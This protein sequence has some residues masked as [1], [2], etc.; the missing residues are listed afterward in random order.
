MNKRSLGTPGTEL[1][2][3]SG[4]NVRCV[5]CKKLS[6]GNL[7]CCSGCGAHLFVL[8]ARCGQK[9]ER[10]GSICGRC[11]GRL[12][13]VDGNG[14]SHDRGRDVRNILTLLLFVGGFAFL[15]VCAAYWAGIKFPRLTP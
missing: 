10:S 2:G 12:H 11:G 15:L 8:C 6:A 13:R 4:V 7:E 5:R 1:A 14:R 3:E 9:N